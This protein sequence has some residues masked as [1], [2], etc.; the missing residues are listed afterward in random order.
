MNGRVGLSVF[1][2]K[3][4]CQTVCGCNVVLHCVMKFFSVRVIFFIS[5]VFFV[6]KDHKKMFLTKSSNQYYK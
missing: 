4:T 3:G 2:W 5:N 6:V 1:M